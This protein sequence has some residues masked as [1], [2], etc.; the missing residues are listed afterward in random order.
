MTVSFINFEDFEDFEDV[1]YFKN[2]D[3]TLRWDF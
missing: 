1:G 3:D 2:V